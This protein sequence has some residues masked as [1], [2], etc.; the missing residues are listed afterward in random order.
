MPTMSPPS[1]GFNANGTSVFHYFQHEILFNSEMIPSQNL[2]F[3]RQFATSQALL[4]RHRMPKIRV[5]SKK[6]LAAK[7][8]K[9]AAK[10]R[11]AIDNS[12]HMSLMDAIAVLRVSVQQYLT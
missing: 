11:K 5:P 8:K 7:A 6:A 9:R 3:T 12:E 4:A 10:A 1:R 2:A